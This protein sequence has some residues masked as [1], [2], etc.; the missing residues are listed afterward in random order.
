MCI[1]PDFSTD[2]DQALCRD[3][4]AGAVFVQLGAHW[5]IAIRR[6]VR[7]HA[8]RLIPSANICSAEAE[9]PAVV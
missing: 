6:K 2:R 4:D 7:L 8:R 1:E 3:R 9:S 5:L